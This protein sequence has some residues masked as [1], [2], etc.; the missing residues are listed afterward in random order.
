MQYIIYK[1]QNRANGKIYIGRTRRGLSRRVKEHVNAESKCRYLKN[2]INKYGIDAF[3]ISVLEFANDDKE[4]SRA[5]KKWILYYN[6]LVPNGYNLVLDTGQGRY[7][8]HQTKEK[9]SAKTQ[10]NSPSCKRWSKYIGVKTRNDCK[11]YLVRIT[12]N[13]KTY[14]KYYPTE[15]EAAEAYDKVALYLYGWNA[16]INFFEKISLYRRNDLKHFF[17]EFCKKQPRTSAYK[18]VSFAPYLKINQWRAAVYKNGKQ[19]NLG[20]YA[21][22]KDAYKAT[23]KYKS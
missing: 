5:E 3:D 23:K 17:E 4:L 15:L 6:S 8:H 13:A 20:V 1:L 14:S 21:T 12:K 11:C 2:A 22:E 16:K 9:L 19:I 7:F 18:G 10:G